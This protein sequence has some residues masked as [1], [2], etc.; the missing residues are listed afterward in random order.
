M[1]KDHDQYWS[2]TEGVF[3]CLIDERRTLA[4][5]NAIKNT[6]RS[7][8]IVVDMGTGSGILAMFAAKAG[9]RRVYAVEFDVKNINTLKE[10]FEKNG[11]GEIIQVLEG[12]V[13]QVTLPEKVDVIVGE[14]IAT[15]VIEELQVYAM[16]NM[17]SCAAENVRVILQQYNVYADLVYNNEEYYGF[18]FKIIRYEY[19]DEELLVSTPLTERH[20]ILTL[21]FRKV[22][23]DLV[24]DREFTLSIQ[25]DGLCNALRISGDTVFSDGSMLGATFAYSYPILLPI[26]TR[27]VKAGEKAAVKIRYK[28][29]G[30]MDTLSY[31]VKFI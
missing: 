24:V 6:V 11:V 27:S 7:G 19:P 2:M 16:N 22:T 10:T 9:A 28:I 26:E 12:D 17:L 30:G 4:F 13:T 5:Q 14:M 29:N 21:D 23:T 8:D 1:Q 3:N 15:G 25:K 20:E 18:D 31:V